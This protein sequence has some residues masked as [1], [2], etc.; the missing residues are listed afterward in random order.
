M[1]NSLLI[2][3]NFTLLY[4]Y[5]TETSEQADQIEINQENKPLP[6]EVLEKIVSYLDGKTLLQFKL[7][8]KSSY[9]VVTNVLRFNKIAWKKF[10]V[11]EIAKRYFIELLSKYFVAYSPSDTLSEF[12]YEQFY[13]NWLQWQHPVFNVKHIGKKDLVGRGNINTIICYKSIVLVVFSN[14]MVLLSIEKN[15]ETESYVITN[16]GTRCQRQDSLVVLNPYHNSMR[17]ASPFDIFT[18][19]LQNNVVVC[20]LHSKNNRRLLNG[21]F[22]VNFVGR[23]IATDFNMYLNLCCWVRESLFEWHS[24]ENATHNPTC[25]HFCNNLGNT[26]FVSLVHGIIISRMHTNDIVVHDM[27]NEGCRV[28]RPWLNNKY[29][30]ATAVYI[31]TDILFIGTQT[32]YLLAYRLKCWADLQTLDEANMLFEMKL[33]IGQIVKLDVMNYDNFRAVVVAS[34]SSVLWIKIN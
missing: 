34:T 31:Y 24:N 22:V 6:P 30:G 8:S 20:P 21:N 19:C 18:T 27:Y 7:L 23:L 5:S 29:T 4:K 12:Q 15:E 32:G 25:G 10:C 2:S 16:K 14:S 17:N 28:I 26:M 9:S 11:N 3:Y 1:I 13:K 33:D